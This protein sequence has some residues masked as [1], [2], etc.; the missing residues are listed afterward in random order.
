VPW[1]A[2]ENASLLWAAATLLVWMAVAWALRRAGVRL[3][4]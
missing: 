3:R 2:P 4:A 1:A